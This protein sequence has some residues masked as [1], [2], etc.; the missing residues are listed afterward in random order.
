MQIPSLQT[1]RIKTCKNL[2]K[3]GHQPFSERPQFLSLLTEGELF[4]PPSNSHFFILLLSVFPNFSTPN[5]HSLKSDLYFF[6][7]LFFHFGSECIDSV[8]GSSDASDDS[9]SVHQ[10]QFNLSGCFVICLKNNTPVLV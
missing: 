8:D 4:S 2:F 7:F 6:F 9:G 1:R 10:F 3:S 5:S